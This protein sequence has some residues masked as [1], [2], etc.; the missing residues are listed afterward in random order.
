[1]FGFTPW[2]DRSAGYYAILGMELVDLEADRGIGTQIEQ[3]LKP[4]VADAMARQ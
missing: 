1:V 2:L 3:T 4:L